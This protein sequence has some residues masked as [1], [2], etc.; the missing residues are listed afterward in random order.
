MFQEDVKQD[1][2]PKLQM[3]FS[4][5]YVHLYLQQANIIQMFV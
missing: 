4:E 2:F 1:M 3:S 5:L